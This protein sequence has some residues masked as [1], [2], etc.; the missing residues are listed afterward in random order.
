MSS[1]TST[2]KAVYTAVPLLSKDAHEELTQAL[3]NE[4]TPENPD[5]TSS[6][7][8]CGCSGMH[9]VIGSVMGVLCYSTIHTIILPYLPSCG[10]AF[11]DSAISALIW[12]A[13]T[14]V[15]AYSLWFGFIAVY[16]SCA[17][18][19]PAEMTDDECQF[20]EDMEYFYAVG[21]FLGFSTSCIV[22]LA[23]VG[24]PPPYLL[25][26]IVSAFIWCRIMA[27]MGK[28]DLQKRTKTVLPTVVV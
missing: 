13:I 21:V 19:L 10:N 18:R 7:P 15:T 8:S 17:A 6:V 5:H 25:A 16:R 23:L 22:S 28:R 14:T 20:W 24:V 27:W 2:S 4:P 26:V 11:A 9:F 3:L 12:S 1:A